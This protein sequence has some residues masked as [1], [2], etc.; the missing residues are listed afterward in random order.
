[1]L[2][3]GGFQGGFFHKAGD[4]LRIGLVGLGT[5]QLGFGESMDFG[6]VDDADGVALADQEIG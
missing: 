3:G 6:G 2:A 4:Q 1:M 5:A